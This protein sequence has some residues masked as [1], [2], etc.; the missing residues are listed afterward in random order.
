MWGLK[1]EKWENTGLD[2]YVLQLILMSGQK[3]NIILGGLANVHCKPVQG[4]PSP[5]GVNS[6][7]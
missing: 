7:I 4:S 5:A 3:S 2:L 6:L 1:L